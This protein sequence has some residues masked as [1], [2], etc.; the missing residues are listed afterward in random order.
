MT[1]E[2]FVA[3]LV[4]FT[5]LIAAIA[6]VLRQLHQTHDLVNSR[7]TELLAVTKAAAHAQGRLDEKADIPPS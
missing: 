5:G 3:I 4:A 1:V 2:Q 7:M 6:G